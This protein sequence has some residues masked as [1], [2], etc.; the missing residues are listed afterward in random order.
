MST[1]AVPSA[2]SL[3]APNARPP[4]AGAQPERVSKMVVAASVAGNALEFYDFVTYAFFAVYIG[5][6]FF[7]ASTP[8]GSLL[9]SVAV[10]GVGFVARPVGGVLIGAF[11][12][13]AGRKPAMLLTI[14]LITIGTLGLALTPS[15]AS[16]GMAA[17]V[18]IVLCRLIQGLALGGEVGPATAFLIEAA[19]P[20]KRALYASWQLA[21]QGMATLIAGIFGVT[22]IA[23]LT[24]N[25]VQA[26]GWRVPFVVG[27]SLLPVA[28]FL[29]RAMPETLH[30]ETAAPEKVGLQGL[31]RYKG[32]LT[33]AVLVVMGGT[34][35]TYVGNYMTTYAITTLKFPPAIAMV[36]TV[37]VGLTTLVFSLVG[38]LLSD[39]YGRKPMMLWPRIITAAIIVPA[40]LLLIS[41]PSV[42]LLL[43]VTVLLAALTAISGGA[44]IVVIPE[45]L[46]RSIRATGLSVAYAIGVSLFG[47]TT[48]FV[49]TWLIQATGNPAAPAW[50]VAGTSVI[51]ALAMMALPETRDKSLEN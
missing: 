4:A 20:E 40:F 25:Q 33:L 12:D 36:A 2:P 32:L 8:M 23:A 51:T 34:V 15:Y 6:A 30:A 27:L 5:R 45:L 26:W 10:F 13:R 29:R 16:I 11:A 37:T 42:P 21:S 35:S 38:G 19:P 22:I 47:G 41:H 39:R 50:Y 44:S 43:S 18:I 14:A 7:P 3:R 17:P 9:L 46:P 1:A 31:A 49:I 28:I 24:E 48:Q